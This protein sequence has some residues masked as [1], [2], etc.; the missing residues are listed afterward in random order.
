MNVSER[1]VPAEVLEALL[2]GALRQTETQL[3]TLLSNLNGTFEIALSLPEQHDNSSVYS[4]SLAGG[5]LRCSGPIKLR[6]TGWGC[7]EQVP[8]LF[9]VQNRRA[10]SHSKQRYRQNRASLSLIG[11]NV[12]FPH[13]ISSMYPALSTPIRVIDVDFVDSFVSDW[14]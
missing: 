13:S 14:L 7:L 5:R 1:A 8:I 4:G 3:R 11:R 9:K 2:H 12:P 10:Q 6:E